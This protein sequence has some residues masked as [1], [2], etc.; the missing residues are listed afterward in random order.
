MIESLGILMTGSPDPDSFN[1]TAH[2]SHISSISNGEE[3]SEPTHQAK[4][5]GKATVNEWKGPLMRLIAMSKQDWKYGIAAVTGSTVVGW[6]T[7][8]TAFILARVLLEYYNPNQ[9][10][11][12]G[13]IYKLS[14]LAVGIGV[15]AIFAYTLQDYSLAVLGER[16]VIRVREMLFARKY[17]SLPVSASLISEEVREY[18]KSYLHGQFVRMS[19]FSTLLS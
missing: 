9:T 7:I 12:K 4:Q 8:A 14:L 5:Q 11:M 10:N 3:G 18:E 13:N 19:T 6:P 2:S 15:S 1:S 16:L 17:E